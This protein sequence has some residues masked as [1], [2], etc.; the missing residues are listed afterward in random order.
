MNH[1]SVVASRLATASAATT[2][3]GDDRILHSRMTRRTFHAI[4]GGM[5]TLGATTIRGGTVEAGTTQTVV[6]VFVPGAER[7]LSLVEGFETMTG[8]TMGIVHWYQ[9]WGYPGDTAFVLPNSRALEAVGARGGTPMITWEAFGPVG[10]PDPARL[11]TIPT[12]VF[13]AH[14][15]AWAWRLKAFGKPIYLR[16]FHEMNYQGYPWSIGMNGNTADD[17]IA[18]WRYIHDRFTRIGAD[19]VQ[20]VWCPNPENAV[21]PYRAIY[22]GD[23]YVDWFGLDIYNGGTQF[24][25]GGWQ[26]P[27]LLAERSYRSMQALNASKPVMLAEASSVEQ[28]GDKGRWIM[29][30]FDVLP[31]MLPNVRAILWFHDDWT[32]KWQGDARLGSLPRA[33]WRVNTSG[34][35]LRAF[36]SIG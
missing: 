7:D 5:L 18:A 21:V 10:S 27:Q 25:W 4:M 12:G 1:R 2:S 26:A 36:Q 17:L 8:K 29:D 3:W 28:G 30:L 9:P 23:A 32:N 19:N 34:S 31:Q 22:P 35:A 6:G 20:W 33:D 15:D 13:D 24:D 16:P 11:A 14:I